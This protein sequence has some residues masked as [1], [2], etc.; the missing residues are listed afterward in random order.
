MLHQGTIRKLYR[1][2]KRATINQA[3]MEISKFF[4]KKL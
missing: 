1:G 3:I 2:E 4:E